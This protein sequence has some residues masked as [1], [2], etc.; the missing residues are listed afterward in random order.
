MGFLILLYGVVVYVFFFAVFLYMTAFMGGDMLAFLG[1]PKTVDTGVTPGFYLGSVASNIMLMLLFAVQHSVMARPGFKR[2][3]TK[4][5]PQ[6]MERGVYLIATNIV[7]IALF[8]YW[9]PMPAV[10][11]AMEPGTWPTVMMV[12]FFV[13]IGIVLLS[14]F[15]INHF[16]LFGLR[17]VWYHYKGEEAPEIPFGTPMLYKHVRHPL[18]LGFLLALWCIPTMT[19][20]HLL[21]S[22]VMTA[23]ILV[24]IGYEERDLL[25]HFGDT[26]RDYM[27]K[28]P[29]I[30][31]FGRRK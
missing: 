27:D 17:Q 18:Y 12:G 7:L 1:A 24:A 16:D 19:V 26:Y 9:Q 5:V 21:F 10:V 13:G 23:Y 11:W 14:T 4:A 28:V 3:L 20:G 8:V 6:S 29:S 22:S 15:L 2:I 25:T 31:P 30:L